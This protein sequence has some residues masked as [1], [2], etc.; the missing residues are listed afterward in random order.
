MK[1]R[2]L[3]F[4][5]CNFCLTYNLISAMNHHLK[6]KDKKVSYL[7]VSTGVRNVINSNTI[8]CL[9]TQYCYIPLQIRMSVS[10]AGNLIYV[11]TPSQ[12]STHYSRYRKLSN[13]ID[14]QQGCEKR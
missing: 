13:V 2:A 14:D 9:V 10:Y 12:T 5:A 4:Y 6:S 11:E 8:K 3:R 7:R 1:V